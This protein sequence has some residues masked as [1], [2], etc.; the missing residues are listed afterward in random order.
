MDDITLLRVIPPT[1]ILGF[2]AGSFKCLLSALDLD[3]EATV[4]QQ[5]RELM[6]YQNLHNLLSVMVKTLRER[7]N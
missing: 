2:D 7:T 6:V 4:S 1:E 3:L 5:K